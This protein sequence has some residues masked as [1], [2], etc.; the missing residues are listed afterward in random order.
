MIV[1]AVART[2]HREQR[3]STMQGPRICM[4]LISLPVPIIYP[5]GATHAVYSHPSLPCL[6]YTPPKKRPQRHW[7]LEQLKS[8]QNPT[9]PA[10]VCT[11]RAQFRRN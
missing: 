11:F 7:P 6:P 5:P 9:P 10:P 8:H 1:E 3:P 2:V 4:P